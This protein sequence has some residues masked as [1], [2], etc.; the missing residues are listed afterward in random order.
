MDTSRFKNRTVVITGASGWMGTAMARRYA[1]EGANLVLAARR[2]EKLDAL[3]EE[4]GSDRAI[5]VTTDV[6]QKEDLE[7][8]VA[9]AVER[10][11]G[12]DVLVQN[13]GTNFPKSLEELT[14]DDWRKLMTINTDSTF[15]GAQA[16]LTELKKSKGAIVNIASTNGLGGD[17]FFTAFNAAK[18][19]VVNFTRGLAVELGEYGIRVNAIAPTLT[20]DNELAKTSPIDGW[21]RKAE[22]RQALPGHAT[23]EDVASATA[24]LTSDDARF[25]TGAILPLDG[26][27]TAFS[28]QAEFL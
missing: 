11:G 1:A 25:I 9:T 28:G 7:K 26:G 13:A 14:L 4:I 16:A 27:A 22:T 20:V 15:L 5:A 2:R 10:F 3:V 24:F 18:G 21:V 8:M 17:R 23:P 19:A 12:I 6:T